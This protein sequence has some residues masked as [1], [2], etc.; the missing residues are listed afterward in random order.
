MI[1]AVDYNKKSSFLEVK[2]KMVAIIKFIFSFRF[3]VGRVA[4]SV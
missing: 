3:G 2:S 4:Q 1:Y